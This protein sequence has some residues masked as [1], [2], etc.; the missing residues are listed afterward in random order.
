MATIDRNCDECGKQYKARIADIKRG[1]GIL[2]S[3]SCGAKRGNRS[4]GSVIT[5][6][7]II[8]NTELKRDQSQFNH[9]KT[10][11]FYC[12]RQC[13]IDHN[14][15]LQSDKRNTR[16]L[17]LSGATYSN[18]HDTNGQFN[19]FI[20]VIRTRKQHAS[21]INTKYL[22]EL[23]SSQRGICPITGW[24]LILPIN[25]TKFDNDS[26]MNASLDR[27]DSKLGYIT[28][29]VRF[30]AK[31][32]NYAKHVYTDDQV[33]EFCEAVVSRRSKMIDKNEFYKKFEEY[34]DSIANGKKWSVACPVTRKYIPV[35]CKP[36]N[37]D[38]LYNNYAD[39]KAQHSPLIT[40]AIEN[41]PAYKIW[42]DPGSYKFF[43]RNDS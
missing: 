33:L 27:I 16:R 8:C 18:D 26:P 39:H 25:C 4:R 20:K 9:S 6:Y 23:W 12:S 41:G 42:N 1:R 5:V 29:N 34:A 36:I 7:C 24:K 28:G 21:N 10:K 13:R 14:K 38:E 2:C 37:I 40:I 15:K 30:I 17:M 22:Q 3:T 11:T 32:A 35:I 19:W 31:I 43:H